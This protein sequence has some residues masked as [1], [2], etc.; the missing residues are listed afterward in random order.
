MR[1]FIQLLSFGFYL[2]S[3]IISV[4]IGEGD[5]SIYIITSK[6]TVSLSKKDN[7]KGIDYTNGK[8]IFETSFFKDKVY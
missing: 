3:E 4:K 1:E 8:N 6:I 2:I 5:E 7:F